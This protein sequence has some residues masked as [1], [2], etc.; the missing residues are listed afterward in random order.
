M[1]GAGSPIAC[2][3]RRRRYPCNPSLC[4]VGGARAGHLVRVKFRF[5]LL[6]ITRSVIGTKFRYQMKGWED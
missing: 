2:R 4:N 6:S 5:G 1:N 3:L